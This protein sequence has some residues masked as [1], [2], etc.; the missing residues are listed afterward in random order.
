MTKPS[1]H[2]LLKF[3]TGPMFAGKTTFLLQAIKYYKNVLKKRVMVFK[4]SK[5]QRFTNDFQAIV[6][7]NFVCCLANG[8]SENDKILTLIKNQKQ[9]PQV[10][11]F[12]EINLFPENFTTI[13]QQLLKQKIKV[14]CSGLSKDFRDNYF[15][16]VK[17]FLQLKPK[18]KILSSNC[19]RC[20]QRAQHSQRLTKNDNLI[21]VGGRELYAPVCTN[22]F[23]T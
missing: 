14:I 15:P 4:P 22:C 20:F 5:D 3:V 17:K 23:Q 6:N 7:H 13:I 12:D 1:F 16:E 2:P 21:L 10:V 11:F 19:Y 9:P 8:V 18:I